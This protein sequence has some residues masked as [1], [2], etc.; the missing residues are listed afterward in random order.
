MVTPT[1][2]LGGRVHPLTGRHVHYVAC[3]VR[4]VWGKTDPREVE[5]FGWFD[6][7][8]LA[9]HIPEGVWEPVQAYLDR[10][11]IQESPSPR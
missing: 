11:L 6:L 9:E 8:E 1:K 10:A 5:D 2:E 7:E 3:D 4:S